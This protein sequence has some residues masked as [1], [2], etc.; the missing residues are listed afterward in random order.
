MPV[1]TAR[2]TSAAGASTFFER[3]KKLKL[4]FEDFLV[5]IRFKNWLI[6]IDDAD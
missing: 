6:N 1:N 4:K 3:E 2:A 5:L